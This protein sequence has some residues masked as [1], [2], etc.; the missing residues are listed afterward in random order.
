MNEEEAFKVLRTMT[1][2][3]LNEVERS[4]IVSKCGGSDNIEALGALNNLGVD[5]REVRVLRKRETSFAAA[6][7]FVY[8]F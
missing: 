6:N 1:E 7:F 5:V 2:W 4:A 3:E 8:R